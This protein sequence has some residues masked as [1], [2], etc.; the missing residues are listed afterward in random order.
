MAKITAW[1]VVLVS[2]LIAG[3]A[4]AQT[5]F[6]LPLKGEKTVVL[7]DKVGRNQ[8]VFVSTAPLEEIHGTAGGVSG[9][10]TFDPNGLEDLTGK[11]VVQV[12]GMK[13][14]ISK[15]DRHL[16]SKDWLDG[17]QYPTISF[18][19]DELEAVQQVKSDAAEG[20]A[21]VRGKA[22]GDFTLHGTTLEMNIPFVATYLPESAETRERAT[23]DFVMV[24]ATFKIA[25][26]DFGIKG[27]RGFVGSRVGETIE[28]RV[29]LYGTT[30][31]SAGTR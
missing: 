9:S 1:V 4:G 12:K 16:Y 25:L 22:V 3:P 21:I 2:V 31:P 17:A 10:V 13:T 15:R 7:S 24:Q 5:G 19:I 11:V 18:E 23:G 26:G 20:S 14:G 28:I 8:M 6:G 27:V 29:S 30:D